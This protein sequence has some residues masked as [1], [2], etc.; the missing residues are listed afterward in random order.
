MSTLNCV[1][2]A[3][4]VLHRIF[5]GSESASI[6]TFIGLGFFSYGMYGVC[7]HRRSLPPRG[8]A[9]TPENSSIVG[10]TSDNVPTGAV[11]VLG[12]NTSPT[13]RWRFFNLLT[14]IFAFLSWYMLPSP[15]PFRQPLEV[16]DLLTSPLFHDFV[17]DS[18]L[19]PP[20]AFTRHCKRRPL[21]SHQYISQN[22]RP[23]QNVTY[24]HLVGN[25]FD[26]TLLIVFFSHARYD[27]NLDS[28]LEMY[29]PYFI[30]VRISFN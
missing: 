6:D 3:Y 4:L 20:H 2:L 21:L 23:D 10:L 16:R 11:R 13:K 15:I 1:P 9:D 28:F 8:A 30:N 26:D 22:L 7:T 17:S 18:I 12:W 24:A 29:T 5:A 14:F 19:L 25:A 27:V